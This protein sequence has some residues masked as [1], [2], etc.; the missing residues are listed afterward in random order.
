MCSILLIVS[1]LFFIKYDKKGY[2]YGLDC[3]FC[4]KNLPFKMQ[5]LY[6]LEYPQRFILIDFICK[7]GYSVAIGTG[8]RHSHSSFIIKDFLSYGYNDTSIVVKCKDSLNNIKY[9]ISYTK[10]DIDNCTPSVHFQDLSS[11]RY[12]E[13]NNN[14]EWYNVDNENIEKIM[15]RKY[16]ILFVGILLTILFFISLV[17]FAR[18]KHKQSLCL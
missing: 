13:I 4:K 18:S 1:I 16:R 2:N 14:Y 9:L 17:R 8:I 10:Y 3:Y 15:H 12:Q 5:P 11:A 6:V 7:D